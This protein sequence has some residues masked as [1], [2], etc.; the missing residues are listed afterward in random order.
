MASSTNK[1]YT[2]RWQRFVSWCISHALSPLN[3]KPAHIANFLA[4]ISA[5]GARYSTVR[6]FLSA[7]AH[8][9]RLKPGLENLGTHPLITAVLPAMR[10]RDIALRP[11]R[12][13]GWDLD[14]VLHD[15]QSLISNSSVA[16][17]THKA[18]FLL[19]FSSGARV[20]ELAALLSPPFFTQ[21]GMTLSFDP[22]FVP[23]RTRGTGAPAPL[24]PLHVP[25]LPPGNEGICPVQAMRRYMLDRGVSQSVTDRLWCH[26]SKPSVSITAR[27]IAAWLR[28]VI[29]GAYRRA[30]KTPEGP[31]NPHSIR[32]AAASWAWHA[33]VPLPTILQQCRWRHES[34]FTAF[35]LRRLAETDGALFKLKPLAVSSLS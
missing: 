1:V 33:N 11:D 24:P 2:C 35:Y 9:L 25:A 29:S 26:P 30:Q 3:P 18:L 6:G 22:I 7:I 20:S 17:R 5:N 28:C 21:D 10:R 16:Q 8:T 19:A 15:L 27:H 14:V 32:A 13:M 4:D 31:I 12:R 23:K 34:T